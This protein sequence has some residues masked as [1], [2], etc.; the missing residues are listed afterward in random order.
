MSIKAHNWG[1]SRTFH[2]STQNRRSGKHSNQSS[3]RASTHT[4]TAYSPSWTTIRTQ[5]GTTRRSV[6]RPRRTSGPAKGKSSHQ[7][8]T[9]DNTLA[10][11]TP[12]TRWHSYMGTSTRSTK[13]RGKRAE[14]TSSTTPTSCADQETPP[15]STCTLRA[16]PTRKPSKCRTG[17]ATSPTGT[18]LTQTRTSAKR[19]G[20]N[21][22]TTGTPTT[23]PRHSRTCHSPSANHPK[24]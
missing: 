3:G 24:C 16:T 11:Q 13:P 7:S 20:N 8:N 19:N 9:M 15:Y 10:S 21:A 17:A 12:L 4:P 14:Q 18:T 6:A 23:Q 5:H 1:L 22:N 2:R